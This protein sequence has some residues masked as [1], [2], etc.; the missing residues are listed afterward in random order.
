MLAHAGFDRTTDQVIEKSREMSGNAS[1][2]SLG[3]TLAGNKEIKLAAKTGVDAD[4]STV[5]EKDDI[6]TSEQQKALEKALVEFPA[7]IAA[8]ERWTKIGE[9]VEG[10]TKKQCVAR[11]KFL[12]DQLK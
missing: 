8:N 11:F 1:L 2:K 7:S 10:K 6:W 9:A 12:R 5:E 3:S 4:K